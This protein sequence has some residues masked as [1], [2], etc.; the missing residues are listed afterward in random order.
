MFSSL[1]IG[2]V[3]DVRSAWNG[4]GGSVAVKSTESVCLV[5]QESTIFSLRLSVVRRSGV[6]VTSQP[7]VVENK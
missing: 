3:C 5:P 1:S 2:A 7:A 4:S 6:K